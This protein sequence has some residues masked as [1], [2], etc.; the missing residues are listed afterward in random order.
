MR[1]TH[2]T[3]RVT[4]RNASERMESIRHTDIRTRDYAMVRLINGA[5]KAGV[6]L[7]RRKEAARRACREWKRGEG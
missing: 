6:Q 2:V 7:D 3:L 5:T 1:N 4:L